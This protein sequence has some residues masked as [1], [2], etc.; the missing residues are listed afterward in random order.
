VA[1]LL[2]KTVKHR[3]LKTHALHDNPLHLSRTGVWCA[4]SR[5][6]IVGP[7]LSEET[8]TAK[9]Y[10]NDLTQLIALL[11]QNER[12]CWFQQDGTTAILRKQEELSC[13]TS[14]VIAL[15]GVAFGH[16][17]HQTVRVGLS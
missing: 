10:G 14:S 4:V 12:D 17:G 15:A 13:R 16:H 5:K 2:V 6:L 9:N 7:F 3:V 1:I 8:I 11:E